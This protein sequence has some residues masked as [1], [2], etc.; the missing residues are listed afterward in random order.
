MRKNTGGFTLM[1]LMIVV[2]IIGILAVIAVPS[3]QQYILRANRAV[4]KTAIMRIAAQQES[5]YNDRK[6]YA[7]ALNVFSSDYGASTV[8]LGRDGRTQTSN[9]PAAIYQLTLATYSAASVADCSA[10]GSPN[11]LQYAIRATPVNSQAKDT[12]CLSLCYGSVGDKGTSAGSASDCWS[13]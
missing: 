9:T 11:A 10:S 8:F 4:A 12:K 2:A 6:G 7:T 1:E 13:R 3:Y 5:Y